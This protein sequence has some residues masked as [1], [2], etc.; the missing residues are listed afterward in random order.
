MIKILM[1]SAKLATPG[2][3]K[4]KVFWNKGYDVISS[5]DEVVNK[6]SSRDSSFVVNVVMWI[7][8]CNPSITMREVIITW[9]WTEK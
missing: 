2:L 6:I 8:F 9:I 3:L 1:I 5:V 4:I 7:T